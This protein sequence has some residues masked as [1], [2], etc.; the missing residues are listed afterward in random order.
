MKIKPTLLV[1][2]FLTGIFSFVSLSHALTIERE[3]SFEYPDGTAVNTTINV[4][5]DY[6]FLSTKFDELT[7]KVSIPVPIEKPVIDIDTIN[8]SSDRNYVFFDCDFYA[9]DFQHKRTDI[10]YSNK[11]S[12]QCKNSAGNEVE[13]VG[14]FSNITMPL[15]EVYS[16]TL[17]LDFYTIV[18][19]NGSIEKDLLGTINL[20]LDNGN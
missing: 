19:S 11:F 12:T 16:S 6:S 10:G 1:A 20:R 17:K 18:N 15:Y 8:Y 13:I 9:D 14:D 3:A 2:T 7:G 4:E 5:A